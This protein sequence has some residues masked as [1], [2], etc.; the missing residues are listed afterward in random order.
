MAYDA[1]K[2]LIRQYIKTNGN[3]DITGQILQ[4]VLVEMVNNYP[5]ISSLASQS[6]VGNNFLPKLD[7]DP[8]LVHNDDPLTTVGNTYTVSTPGNHNWLVF[9]L[10]PDILEVT[11]SIASSGTIIKYKAKQIPA[12]QTIVGV[13]Y[14]RQDN[15]AMVYVD[16]VKVGT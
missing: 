10:Q 8:S 1:L 7:F 5:D 2:A 4:N 12:S 14:T 9:S 13:L 3:N 11:P 15:P 16:Y 6:W